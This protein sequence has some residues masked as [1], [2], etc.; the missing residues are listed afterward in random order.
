MLKCLLRILLSTSDQVLYYADSLDMNVT[1]F[2]KVKAS[3]GPA[4]DSRAKL[5]GVLDLISIEPLKEINLGATL[6]F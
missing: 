1:V 3:L 2:L 5:T 4:E 6:A